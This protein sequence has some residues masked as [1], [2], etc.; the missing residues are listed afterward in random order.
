MPDGR[1]RGGGGSPQSLFAA[2]EGSVFGAPARRGEEQSPLRVERAQE[3]FHLVR[4]VGGRFVVRR[5][6]RRAAA[7]GVEEGAGRPGGRGVPGGVEQVVPVDEVAHG[8]TG[9]DGAFILARGR[10]AGRETEQLAVGRLQPVGQQ[11]GE[12]GAAGLADVHLV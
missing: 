8:G 2:T 3:R 10:V 11:A 12:A 4:P 6:H 9:G 5:R 7:G 1:G